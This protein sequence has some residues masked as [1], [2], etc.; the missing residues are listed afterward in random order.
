M[1]QSFVYIVPECSPLNGHVSTVLSKRELEEMMLRKHDTPSDLMP[2]LL[3]DEGE[4]DEV[5]TQQLHDRKPSKTEPAFFLTQADYNAAISW[6]FFEW[7]S[8][9][10]ILFLQ[11]WMR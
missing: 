6:V 11:T 4:V 10:K 5:L 9:V 3:G 8:E 7:W 2:F 1:N